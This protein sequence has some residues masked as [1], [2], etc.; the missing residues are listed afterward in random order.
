MLCVKVLSPN[1]AVASGIPTL[2]HPWKLNDASGQGIP[3]EHKFVTTS[4]QIT[5]LF[6]CSNLWMQKVKQAVGD[7]L[8]RT[9]LS[10]FVL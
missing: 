5:S 4:V 7:L 10:K 6:L 3:L 8:K 2:C 1:K 9:D